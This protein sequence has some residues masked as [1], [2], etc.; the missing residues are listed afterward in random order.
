MQAK[1]VAKSSTGNNFQM[2]YTEVMEITK[3]FAL[4]LRMLRGSLS[5]DELGKKVGV[6]SKHIYDLE[7]ERKNPSIDLI[8]KLAKELNTTVSNLLTEKAENRP[9]PTRIQGRTTDLLRELI[10]RR[11]KIPEDVI[12]MAQGFEL[13]DEVWEEVREAFEDAIKRRS[14]SPKNHSLPGSNGA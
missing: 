13:D 11:E 12:D 5:A 8:E 3:V 4:N 7:K 2:M 6:T 9:A 10:F 14:A 1:S